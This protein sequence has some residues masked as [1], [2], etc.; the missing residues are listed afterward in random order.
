MRTGPAMALILPRL[1]NDRYVYDGPVRIVFNPGPDCRLCG[2]RRGVVYVDTP[3]RGPYGI[4]FCPRCDV[5]EVG[6]PPITHRV[7]DFDPR[8]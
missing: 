7:R 3:N 8:P 6:G 5:T 4:A 1:R 2:G